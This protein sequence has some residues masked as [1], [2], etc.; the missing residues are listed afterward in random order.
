MYFFAPLMQLTR[1]SVPWAQKGQRHAKRSPK[2]RSQ[3]G[4]ILL[5]QYQCIL[6]VFHEWHRERLDAIVR[7]LYYVNAGQ[8]NPF[9]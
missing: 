9:F 2:T 6:F 7:I 1:T 8:S 4:N 3:N 5:L